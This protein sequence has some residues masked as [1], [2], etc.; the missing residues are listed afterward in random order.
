VDTRAHEQKKKEKKGVGGART[1]F[2]KKGGS[3]AQ[4][5]RAS[6]ICS[7]SRRRRSAAMVKG[8]DKKREGMENERRVKKKPTP[9]SPSLFL[10]F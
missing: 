2:H 5:V 10:S 3:D 9:L 4:P 7:L 8:R 6:S 1:H